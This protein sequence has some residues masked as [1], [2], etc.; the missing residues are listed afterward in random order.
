M[1]AAGSPVTGFGKNL[2]LKSFHTRQKCLQLVNMASQV[3]PV[4]DTGIGWP[5]VFGFQRTPEQPRWEVMIDAKTA[6]VLA[7]EDKN[8]YVDKQITGGIYPLTSTEICP[9]NIRCGILQDNTPMPFTNTG[10]AAPNDFTNSAGVYDYTSGTV[11]T[12][13]M[14]HLIRMPS[15]AQIRLQLKVDA[16]VVQQLLPCFQQHLAKIPLF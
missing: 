12:T 15:P 5:W 1:R 7:F 4:P 14:Q 13:S 6:E 11:V 2:H 3:Q 16:A 8:Q 10:F 9:D